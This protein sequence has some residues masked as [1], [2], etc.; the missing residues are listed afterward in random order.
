MEFDSFRSMHV[1]MYIFTEVDV[2]RKFL[3]N[4]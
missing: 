3:S 2:L 1:Y 4:I